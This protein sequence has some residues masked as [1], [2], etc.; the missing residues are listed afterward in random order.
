MNTITTAG[1]EQKKTIAEAMR[2]AI[3]EANKKEESIG[4]RTISMLEA[5]GHSATIQIEWVDTNLV[6]NATVYEYNGLEKTITAT[7]EMIEDYSYN[8]RYPVYK[9]KK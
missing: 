2:R 5:S 1:M 7:K 9:E 6:Y 4:M 3:T 8:E